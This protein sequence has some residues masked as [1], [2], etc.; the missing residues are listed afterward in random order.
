MN[1]DA[2]EYLLNG[3]QKA[4]KEDEASQKAFLQTICDARGMRMFDAS[5][6]DMLFIPNNE[7]LSLYCG[8]IIKNPEY[9][10]YDYDGKCIWDNTL[11]IPI[12]DLTG[13]IAGIGAFNP[14]NYV[15]AHETQDWSI[16][17]YYYSGKQFFKKGLF[18]FCPNDSYRKAL[19]DGYII[20]VDG[21][22][23]AISLTEA[24]YNAA[25]LMGSSL[26]NER[27]VLL[28]LIDNIIVIPDNDDAG[29]ELA[30]NIERKVKGSRVLKQAFDKDVD[31]AL[32]SENRGI[33]LQM[34]E[35]V[36][37]ESRELCNL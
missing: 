29:L 5:K 26:T 27:V 17:Y 10:V 34:I 7:Y 1:S 36:V 28:R 9:G 13:K 6:Y 19:D 35:K 32:K 18:L 20:V 33:M 23:D 2:S 21:L 8:E 4:W 22:F 11:L 3:I 16:I 15:Q 31:G 30:K 14:F 25:A 24:G 12:K 37:H